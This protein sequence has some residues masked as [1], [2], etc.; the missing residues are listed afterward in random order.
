[1][2]PPTREDSVEL[3]L[4]VEA[5]G[6]SARRDAQAARLAERAHDSRLAGEVK[7]L[8]TTGQMAEARDR[9]AL[10][11]ARQQRRAARIAY[12]FLRDPAEVDEAV[13]EAFVRVFTHIGS[14]Q[15]ALPFEVWFTRILINNCLDRRKARRRRD[16][17]MV[18]ALD[19]NADDRA[20]VEAAP[21]R[22]LSPEDHLLQGEQR[23]QLA[24]ALEALPE[25]Q[26][27]VVSLCLYDD[28]SPR[29]VS[30]ITGMNQSTVRVHLFR[31][32][33]KLRG[34]L[35]DSRDSRR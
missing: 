8:V 16:R 13:Q 29:E 14:Y 7:G 27:T 10:L 35:E 22:D 18:A 11:V 21:S 3:R 12:H 33:R 31:A 6:T 5:L 26:R 25:R 32:L 15:E 30:D 9:F 20:R 23:R 24:R 1:V 4:G 28:C 19:A 34:L 17:W 2:Q